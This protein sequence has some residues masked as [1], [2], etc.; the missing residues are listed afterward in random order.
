M[1]GNWHKQQKNVMEYILEKGKLYGSSVEKSI[2]SEWDTAQLLSLHQES[3]RQTA[4][5][6]GRHSVSK[7]NNELLLQT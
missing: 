5:S 4:W 1:G 3:L 6:I 2:W 7:R